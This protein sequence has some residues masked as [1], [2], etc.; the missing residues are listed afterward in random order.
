M[1]DPLQLD[2]A[3]HHVVK[4]HPV[5]RY[6]RKVVR[7][8]RLMMYYNLTHQKYI[9]GIWISKSQGL[10]RE[11]P[12]SSISPWGFGP[13]AWSMILEIGSPLQRER[14]LQQGVDAQNEYRR[15][16]AKRDDWRRYQRGRI[17][18]LKRRM[19]KRGTRWDNP[20]LDVVLM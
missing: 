11:L 16:V 7:E 13:Q 18:S 19:A 17:S 15:A 20:A 4:N 10:I 3:R 1:I 5:L 8:P 14:I 9:L 2:P 12:V 6:G